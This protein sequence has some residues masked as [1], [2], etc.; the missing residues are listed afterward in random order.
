MF[1]S[2]L[3]KHVCDLVHIYICVCVRVFVF[4]YLF[5]E[6]ICRERRKCGIYVNCVVVLRKSLANIHRR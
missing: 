2:L 3:H 5:E 6:M 4:L 1:G